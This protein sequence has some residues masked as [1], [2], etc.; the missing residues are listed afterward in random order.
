MRSRGAAQSWKTQ[1]LV[2]LLHPDLS[3]LRT[4]NRIKRKQRGAGLGPHKRQRERAR[5]SEREASFSSV[6][7]KRT[8]NQPS[9]L[10]KNMVAV[11]VTLET[12]PKC[13][14]NEDKTKKPPTLERNYYEKSG[15]NLPP[16]LPLPSPAVWGAGAAFMAR[17]G[18][19]RSGRQV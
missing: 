9:I 10:Y 11:T 15:E 17:L 13:P 1:F 2:F 6:Y 19:R 12:A 14:E 16:L 7:F 18:G 5:S 8:K 4:V 3:R